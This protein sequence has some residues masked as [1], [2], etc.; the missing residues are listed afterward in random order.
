[1]DNLADRETLAAARKM[2]IVRLPVMTH[3]GGGDSEVVLSFSLTTSQS[4]AGRRGRSQRATEGE[5][6]SDRDVE[7][8]R[9]RWGVVSQSLFNGSGEHPPSG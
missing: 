6:E 4:A 7:G 2:K 3:S 8:E 9:E 1:M 5:R